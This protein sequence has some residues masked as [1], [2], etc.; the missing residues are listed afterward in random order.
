VKSCQSVLA[1]V[2]T[3][4]PLALT[5]S[6][7]AARAGA[8]VVLCLALLS[9]CGATDNGVATKPASQILA[10]TR[11]AAQ[12]ASS[13]HVVAN[14][15]ILKG[16]PLELDA[17]LSRRQGYARVSFF[18]FS[19][20]AIR[21]GD[22]IYVKGNQ[23]FNARLESTRG[24]NVPSG[25]WLKGGTSTLGQ[26]GTFTDISKE[27]PLI[28]SGSGGVIKG[29]TTKIGGQP[30]IAL[31]LTR[32]LYTGTLYVATTG[33]PYPLKLTKTGRETGG[34]TFTG[35]NDPVTVSPPANAVEITKL[36]PSKNG[37]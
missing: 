26:I 36:Q 2:C 25:R 14:S 20:E 11:T 19:L 7:N 35:W 22:T 10:A 31:K 15:K 13:V 16:R 27:L 6:M 37:R 21:S 5:R 30:A 28:L 24:V 29:K 4:N 23:A 33:K 8:G 12:S 32:K 34:T 3:G 18:G 17:S 1:R 9:G